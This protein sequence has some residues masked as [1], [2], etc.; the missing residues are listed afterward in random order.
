M[1]GWHHWLNAYESEWT[2]GVGDGPGGLACCDSWGR[3]ESDTTERL[4]W[5]E[6]NWMRVFLFPE[7][8]FFSYKLE[9]ILSAGVLIRIA[10]TLDPTGKKSVLNFPLQIILDSKRNLRAPG[11]LGY[12]GG[13]PRGY[14]R[15]LCSVYFQLLPSFSHFP[16]PYP[17]IIA[18]S[19]LVLPHGHSYNRKKEF[20]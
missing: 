4:N 10:L 3:K 8:R 5:T 7:P 2:L 17:L 15:N 18:P 9:I 19:R 6:L 13:D 16:Y 11:S 14:R 12:S 1:A 20:I